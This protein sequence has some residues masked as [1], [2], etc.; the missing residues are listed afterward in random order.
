MEKI[1][2]HQLKAGKYTRNPNPVTGKAQYGE[3]RYAMNT[4]FAKKLG[5]IVLESGALDGLTFSSTY[6]FQNEADWLAVHVEASPVSFAQL[7]KNRPDCVNVHAALCVRETEVHYIGPSSAATSGAVGGVMEFMPPGALDLFWPKDGNGDR[8]GIYGGGKAVIYPVL[9]RR[10]DS[11]LNSI[12]LSH[13]DL[14]ILDVE[15]AE[16]E[17]LKTIDL[18]RVTIDVIA[19]ELDGKN[20]QKDADVNTFLIER[21]YVAHS[22][23][24]HQNTWFARKQFL[25]ENGLAK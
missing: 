11:I 1:K 5:G 24:P 19:I 6:L 22:K 23:F 9:C 18:N 20:T 12:G 3:D 15:G 10:L 16:L 7:E 2:N 21:G 14:W 13:V 17:V 4:F 8:R 25:T